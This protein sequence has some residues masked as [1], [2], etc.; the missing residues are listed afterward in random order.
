VADVAEPL[1]LNAPWQYQRSE[2]DD[3]PAVTVAVEKIAAEEQANA[4]A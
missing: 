3:E 4:A 2:L 1:E